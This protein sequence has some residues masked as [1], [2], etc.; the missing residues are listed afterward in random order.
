MRRGASALALLALARATREPEPLAHVH[1]LWEAI[2]FYAQ[3]T[4]VEPMFTK[5]ELNELRRL[6]DDE[7]R[8]LRSE[9]QRRRVLDQFGGLTTRGS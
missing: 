5:A 9:R 4:S 8:D 1:A 6:I 3:R 7:R 2:E